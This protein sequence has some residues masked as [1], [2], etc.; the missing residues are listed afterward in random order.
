M[1]GLSLAQSFRGTLGDCCWQNKSI[2]V[3]QAKLV[4]T[5]EKQEE[6]GKEEQSIR[7]DFRG[8]F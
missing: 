5:K 2:C 8:F 1:A 7:K 3:K 6:C 4:K